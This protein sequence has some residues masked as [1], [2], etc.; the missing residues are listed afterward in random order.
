M[1]AVVSTVL[2]LIGWAAITAG[3]FLVSPRVGLITGGI[4]AVGYAALLYDPRDRKR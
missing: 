4:L 2:E 1:T 3:G